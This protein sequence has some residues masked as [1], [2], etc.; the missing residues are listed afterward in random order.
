MNVSIRTIIELNI[1]HYRELL[2]G[3]MDAAKRR[4]VERLLAEEQ[5]K[6]ANLRNERRA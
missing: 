6:L 3:E 1:A 5:A 4:T 2:R